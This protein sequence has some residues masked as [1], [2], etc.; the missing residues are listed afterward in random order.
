WARLEKMAS[1]A[2]ELIEKTP[3]PER[4]VEKPRKW[5]GKVI[6]TEKTKLADVQKR[7]AEFFR[8]FAKQTGLIRSIAVKQLEQ[9]PLTADETKILRDVVQ[10]HRGSGSTTYNGWYPKLFYSGPRDSGKWDALVADVHTD[11]PAPVLNDP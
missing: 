10:I 4:V 11:V 3:F 5:N 2:A 7:Q 8:N 9:K 1:R 6:G